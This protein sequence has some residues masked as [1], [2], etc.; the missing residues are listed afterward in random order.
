M[1][2]TQTLAGAAEDFLDPDS[3]RIGFNIQRRL[4]F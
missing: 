2:P 4:R 1:N 3:W